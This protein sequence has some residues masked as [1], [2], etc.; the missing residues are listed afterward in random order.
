MKYCGRLSPYRLLTHVTRKR[1]NYLETFQ[2]VH[3]SPPLEPVVQ[4]S[5]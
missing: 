4:N 3:T 5:Q 2:H 1:G